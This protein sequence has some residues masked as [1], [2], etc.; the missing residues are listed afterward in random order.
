MVFVSPERLGT[1]ALHRCFE[2]HECSLLV[3][4]EAHCVS[5][6]SHN[7]RPAF[8][9]VGDVARTK[10]KPRCILALTATASQAVMK[11][12]CDTLGLDNKP[13]GEGGDVFAHS[14]RRDNLRLNV[15]GLLRRA[16]KIRYLMS[17]VGSEGRWRRRRDAGR[18]DEEEEE[19]EGSS[20]VYVR[21]P[22]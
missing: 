18:G 17:V 5:Q 15:I 4:D 10:I 21:A 6:W 14:W 7:F 22:I 20:V 3:V 19:Q 1:R 2:S 11:D 9:K 12:V 8:L 16:S 13:H